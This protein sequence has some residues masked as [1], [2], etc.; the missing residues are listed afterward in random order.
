MLTMGGTPPPLAQQ[1]NK[2]KIEIQERPTKWG[3]ENEKTFHPPKFH[4]IPRGLPLHE[5]EYLM[6]LSRLDELIKKKN[7]GQLDLSDIECRSPS[8]EPIY[9]KEGKRLNTTEKRMKDEMTIEIQSLIDECEMMNPRFVPP[10]EFRNMKK[11]RKIFLPE[12]T[13]GK[14]NYAG[15]ILGQKGENQKRIEGKTG[16]KI[17]LRGR[18]AYMVKILLLIKTNF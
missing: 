10:H 15:L 17:S 3:K 16:C 12:S 1:A 4:A 9:D 8:P 18:Q 6:R 13:D 5:V 14:N 2:S 7:I 11:T